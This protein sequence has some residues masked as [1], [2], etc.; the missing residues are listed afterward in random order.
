MPCRDYT[1]DISY[2]AT[3]EGRK[4]LDTITRLAC[5]R[6]E[7]YETKGGIEAVP[8]WA[9]QWWLLHKM[10]DAEERD[11]ERQERER[12]EERARA[13]AKLTPEER[14]ALGIRP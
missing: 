12:L 14:A 11:R 2:W 6:C 3:S 4:T 13:L 7:E 1:D 9:Q 10:K 5:E 8:Q